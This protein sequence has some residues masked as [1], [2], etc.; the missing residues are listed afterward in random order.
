MNATK[1]LDVVGICGSLRRDS[2]NRKALRAAQELMPQSMTMQA[3]EIGDLPMY[4]FDLHQSGFPAPVTHLYERIKA[5][6]GVLIATPEHNGSIP[7]A[8]K[9]V[10]DWMSRFKP[11]PFVNM[12]CAV[13]SAS[14]GPLGG[15][16]VQYDLRRSMM[17]VQALSC[18]SRKSSS[19]THRPSSTR[20]AGLP[21]RSAGKSWRSK[22][23]P[24][25]NGSCASGRRFRRRPEARSRNDS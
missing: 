5:A 11:P 1:Q 4:N 9:N 17:F 21:M 14:P 24:F 16:R 13:L 18:C 15:G 10:I 6:D 7:A 20:M 12:P 2:F 8:L 25:M 22:W 23:Q 3:V 19:P